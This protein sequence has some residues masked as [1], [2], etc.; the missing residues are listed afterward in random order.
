MGLPVDELFGPTEADEI[1]AMMNE[2]NLI[3][4]NEGVVVGRFSRCTTCRVADSLLFTVSGL[5]GAV[6]SGRNCIHNSVP[7]TSILTQ[8]LLSL[9][10]Y[11]LRALQRLS[12]EWRALPKMCNQNFWLSIRTSQWT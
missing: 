7:T 11:V 3:M 4:F 2:E 6:C 8:S 10:S 12:D 5:S 1:L 9:V